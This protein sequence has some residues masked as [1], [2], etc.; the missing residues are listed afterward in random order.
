MGE[1]TGGDG[2]ATFAEASMGRGGGP[3]RCMDCIQD[4]CMS[5]DD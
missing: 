5:W 4:A 2:I 1:G 3:S